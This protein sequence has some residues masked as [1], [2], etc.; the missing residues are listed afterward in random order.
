MFESF[1]RDL[2]GNF[3]ILSSIVFASL[4]FGV[5]M[6]VNLADINMRKSDFQE[7]L[8]SAVLAAASRPD[9]DTSARIALAE[10]MVGSNSLNECVD[11]NTGFKIENGVVYGNLFCQQVTLFNKIVNPGFT[12]IYVNAAAE[13]LQGNPMCVLSLNLSEKKGLLA[14]GGSNIVANDCSVHVN[15][16]STEA[17]V[18]SGGSTLSSDSNCFVG[19]V[20]QGLDKMTPPPEASCQPVSDPFKS[21]MKPAVGACD[22]VNFNQNTDTTM[23]PGTY[24]GGMRVSNAKFT[25]Q[26]GLYIIDNGTFESTGG[27]TLIG[28]GVTFFLTGKSAQAGI[29]W[30]GGGTYRFTAMKTGTLA[31]FIVYLDPDAYKDDTSVV[32]GGGDIYYEGAFYFPSQTL[33]I[34]GGGTV[35]SPSPFTAYVADRIE[36]TGGGTLSIGAD[37]SAAS[38]PIPAGLYGGAGVRQVRLVH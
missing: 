5:G 19:K 14:S 1:W 12:K 38:V 34:S 32:S 21:I 37:P 24:C 17:V 2:R 36:Y 3:T 4:T 6:A 16:A 7:A 30:S 28:D 33:L 25:F 26:P 23:Y 18:F 22:Y 20:K 15:S 31:G 27:A 13:V 8:D 9:L 29:V 35:N 11:F 10:K